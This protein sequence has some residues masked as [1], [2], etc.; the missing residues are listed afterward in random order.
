MMSPMVQIASEA[1]GD[2]VK[3]HRRSIVEGGIWTRFVCEWTP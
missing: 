1:V 3:Y 2:S